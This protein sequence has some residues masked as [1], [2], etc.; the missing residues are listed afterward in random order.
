MANP[1]E[2]DVLRHDPAIKEPT[3]DVT[4]F[5]KRDKEQVRVGEW[6]RGECRKGMARISPLRNEFCRL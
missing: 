5:M 4:A 3:P 2:G 1:R 6:G